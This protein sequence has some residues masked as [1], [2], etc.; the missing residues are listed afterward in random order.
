MAIEPDFLDELDR[1]ESARKRKISS[2]FAGEQETE[3]LGEGLTFSDFRRYSPGDDTRLIDWKIFARTDELFIKQYEAERNY[4][5]HVLVDASGSMDFGDGDAHKFEFGAKIGLGFC[6]LTADEHNDFRFSVFT[7]ESERLDA[8]R[9]NRGEVLNLVDRC[10]GVSLGRTSDFQQALEAY[11]SAIKNRSLVIVVSDLLGDPEAI[12]AGLEALS[13]NALVV[14]RVQAPGERAPPARGDTIFEDL[15]S[16]ARRRT[17]FG[18]RTAQSY[19]QRLEDHIAAVAERCED[20][21]ARHELVDTGE[22][23]FD[24]FSQVW[25]E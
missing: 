1:F 5:V 14:A 23:F 20:I 7:D 15:E 18:G 10:N 4:T 22:D 11:Q 6:Y 24:A 8:G 12:D 13:G 3:R 21:R 2:R 9:S 17:Y 19:R 25:V 16:D